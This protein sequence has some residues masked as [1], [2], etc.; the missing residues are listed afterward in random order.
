MLQTKIIPRHSRKRLKNF[1]V[2]TGSCESDKV[3]IRLQMHSELRL[4]FIMH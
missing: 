1:P 2:S 3:T 4:L